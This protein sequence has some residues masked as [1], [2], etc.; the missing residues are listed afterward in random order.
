MPP[1][2]Q[3][4]VT[5]PRSASRLLT[6]LV[7]L[8]FS[9]LLLAA[10]GQQSVLPAGEVP[11]EE[12]QDSPQDGEEQQPGDDKDA[13]RTDGDSISHTLSLLPENT[14]Y[15]EYKGL[16]MVM[17]NY[18]AG[19]APVPVADFSASRVEEAAKYGNSLFTAL[20]PNWVRASYSELL[21]TLQDDSH[22][23]HLE[24]LARTAYENDVVLH[25]YFWSYLY[26]FGSDSFNGSDM[27]WDDPRSD[28]GTVVDGYTKR[29][30]HEMAI[31]RAVE[32]T[33]QYPN[34]VYNMMWE[35][36]TRRNDGRS[37]FRDR[38]GDFHRWWVE[39]L[40]DAGEKI[41]PEVEH[42][43]S[44][45]EGRPLPGDSEPDFT[46]RHSPNFIVDEDGN[47]FWYSCET[48]HERVR[49][50]EVPMVFISS[51]YPFGD[52]NFTSWDRVTNCPRTRDNGNGVSDYRI[53]P[54]D[55]RNMV[56]GGFHP[57]E[58][59]AQAPSNTRNYYLQARWYMEN[60]GVLES[61]GDG[62][63]DTVPG[64][65]ASARPALSNPEG[66]TNGRNGT[67]FAAVYSH[68]E[69]LAPA[70]AEVW[71]DVNGDGRFS[72]DPEA[73]ERFEMTAHG[74]DFRNGV[75]YT[76]D[77]PVYSSYIFRFADSNWNPPMVGGLVPGNEQG[78]SYQHWE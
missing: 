13:A 29:D 16:P 24:E 18:Q 76:V 8:I 45:V 27:I 72:P 62:T 28:G 22:W 39:T 67:T 4:E 15:F 57:A 65:R 1:I 58:A 2:P 10:C 31:E 73:G 64:Y 69:G 19:L 71:I 9:V 55:V 74:D 7:T 11:V 53:T 37:G 66:Y 3:K 60:R 77:A 23:E 35:Y 50:Y 40:R 47:G 33:W 70:Q 42:L 49:Q 34:V 56:R 48:G 20:H 26:N 75:L 38:N 44:I 14:R 17:F 52:N 25:L 51:D 21:R 68:P 5:S 61:K 41:D 30:L 32:A 63:I 12:Q 43:V 36:N 78:I 46:S 59:W 54:E 6:L